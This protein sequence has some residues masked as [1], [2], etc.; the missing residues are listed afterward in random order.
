MK[1]EGTTARRSRKEYLYVEYDISF[2]PSDFV[3]F[4]IVVN[5]LENMSDIL[6]NCTI[7][8]VGFVP[9]L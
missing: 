7:E 5:Q 2:S 1:P 9:V 6:S 8:V 3:V 4:F